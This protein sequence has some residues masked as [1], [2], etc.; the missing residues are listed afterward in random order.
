MIQHEEKKKNDMTWEEKKK[1]DNE[2]LEKGNF[3]ETYRRKFYSALSFFFLT[4][5]DDETFN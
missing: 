5:F 2:N 3:K 1:W 4:V